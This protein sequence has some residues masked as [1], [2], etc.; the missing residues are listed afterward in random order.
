MQDL[1]PF[2]GSKAS[3]RAVAL[4]SACAH[5]RREAV[6]PVLFNA[7]RPF[8]HIW[9]EPAADWSAERRLVLDQ[10]EG[11]L[12]RPQMLLARDGFAVSRSVR[13]GTPAP[14]IV[15][16]AAELG[17][18]AIMMGMR[19]EGVLRGF[20]LGSVAQRIPPTV[21]CPVILVKPDSKLPGRA[22]PETR[23]VLPTDGSAI[24]EKAVE[25]LIALRPLFGELHVDVV[26][27][28]PPLT[29]RESFMPPYDDIQRRRYGEHSRQAVAAAERRLAEAGISHEVSL[30][31]GVPAASIAEFAASR[32]ADLIAMAT[33]S[34]GPLDH[35]I[36]GSVALKTVLLA[37][38]PVMLT[39]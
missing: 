31:P 27:F 6:A 25:H 36:F 10:G 26:H 32:E 11:I 21:A 29:V 38:V 20:A 28:E 1:L 7:R 5:G 23:V 2:D 24:S 16:I 39:H 9:P 8:M 15:E 30:L 17:V 33:H 4:F 37:K 12:A 19:G 35:A 3:P 18:S 34:A 13:I 22:R 14:L